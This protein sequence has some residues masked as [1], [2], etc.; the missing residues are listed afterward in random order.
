MHDQD[1]TRAEM[2]T[3]T[4][5][6]TAVLGE[7]KVTAIARDCRWLRRRGKVMPLMLVAA[8]LSTLGASSAKWLADIL[9]TFRAFTG[10]QI[11]YK[12]FHKQLAKAA[13]PEMFRRLF[14]AA[15]ERL[16]APVLHAVSAKL[17]GFRDI[18]IHDGTS[19]ALKSDLRNVWPGRFTKI[20]PAAVELHVTMSLLEDE[21]FQVT[22]APDKETERAFRPDATS[23]VGRLFLGD[24]GYEERK[25]FYDVSEAGGFFI[26]RGTKSIRPLI[27]AAFN[28]AGKPIR[29]LVGKKLSWE[30]LRKSMGVDLDIEWTFGK[31]VYR[32]RLIAIDRRGERNKKTFVYL[33]TNVDRTLFS[34][35]DVG[36]TY[37]LRWQVELLFKEC[38]SHANLHAFDTTKAPIAEAMIWASLLAALLK[39]AITHF[40]ERVLKLELSTQRAAAS[41]KHYLDAV[42]LALLTSSAQLADVLI[43]ALEFLNVNARRAHPARDRKRG[44]LA[45]GL[46]HSAVRG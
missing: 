5:R 7:K 33:H 42:L 34:A 41:G 38:K 3:F 44:R 32:G 25:F 13:T 28:F 22:L 26:V 6:L 27:R 31:Q 19:F 35:R 8:V 36:E 16:T 20:S 29:T 23:L 4:K 24:R 10:L 30:T 11:A 18:V 21:A 40:A 43:E 17:S 2:A 37:R 14:E 39:R 1:C 15:L 46:A 45:M 9:R 12:P